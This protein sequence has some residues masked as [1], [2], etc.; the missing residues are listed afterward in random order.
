MAQSTLVNLNSAQ[1]DG[2]NLQTQG[3][4]DDRGGNLLS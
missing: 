1:N 4:G 2:F 3:N